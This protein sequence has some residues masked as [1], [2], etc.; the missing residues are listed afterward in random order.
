LPADY[1]LDAALVCPVLAGVI[2]MLHVLIGLW[3]DLIR[4]ASGSRDDQTAFMTASA[5]QVFV[6]AA[7]WPHG[8]PPYEIR[9]G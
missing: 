5:R 7:A 4:S 3:T 1:L 6:A 9:P 2:M 8:K